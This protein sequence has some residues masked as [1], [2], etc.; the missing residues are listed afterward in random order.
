LQDQFPD[1][2]IGYSDH[3]MGNMA[4]VLSV[5]FGVNIIAKHFTLD[6]SFTPISA[7]I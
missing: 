3:T 5:A 7:T 4:C 6:R 2:V 1:V